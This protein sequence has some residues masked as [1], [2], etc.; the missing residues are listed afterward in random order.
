MLR[1]HKVR[2]EP[3]NK[4]ASGLARAAGCA[5]FAWNW[6]LDWW[7]AEY[8]QFKIGE[9]ESAPNQLEARRVLNALKREQF[10]WMLESTKCAPQEA[11]INLGR[12][13]GNFFSGRAKYPKFKKKGVHDAFKLS[14]GN[15][16]VSEN[17]LRVPN[18][19]WITMSELPRFDGII[20]AVTI[21]RRA[22]QWFAALTIDT[23]APE[24]LPPTGRT[25]GVDV[26]V[27]EFAT[28]DGVQFETPRAL[29]KAERKL[30]RANR[31]LSRKRKGSKNRAKAHRRIVN[32]HAKIADTRGD[33][34][35]KLTTWLV[36]TYDSIAI[37]D[38][39]V[40]GMVRNRHLA[41]SVLEAGFYEFRRQLEYKTGLTGRQLVVA[42]RWF[43]SSKICS[44]CRA[45]TKQRMT[46]SVR[47]W[48]CESC[49]ATHHRDVNA[50][51]NLDQL[52]S[53][54]VPRCQ[55]VE[56]SP[57]LPASGSTADGQA[58]SVKQEPDG[59]LNK[60]A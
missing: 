29:R 39:N 34:L 16:E 4:Q 57:P 35:H 1:S 33:W 50:A 58:A 55:P 52:N 5:R 25:V 43:A 23:I 44:A 22:G 9:R 20:Q 14:S 42:D 2:L 27:R 18:L 41:K 48:I 46:L 56:S 37:E 11:L 6:G 30:K 21:S 38:L 59:T 49:G 10:P 32:T 26:G 31:A 13:F 8:E 36:E 51:M 19:G 60:V 40:R 54:G 7:Q 15:F 47:E 45:K 53:P 28:Q 3:N 12:A 24:T 17:R